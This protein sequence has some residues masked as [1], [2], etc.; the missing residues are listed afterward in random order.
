[1]R[2]GFCTIVLHFCGND[3]NTGQWQTDVTNHFIPAVHARGRGGGGNKYS[4]SLMAVIHLSKTDN[5][6]YGQEGMCVN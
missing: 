3:N 5:K 4:I 6:I 1:M 2:R